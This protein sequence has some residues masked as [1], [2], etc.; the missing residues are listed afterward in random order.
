MSSNAGNQPHDHPGAHRFVPR[1][2]HGKVL[3]ANRERIIALALEHG[4]SNVRVFGSTARGTDTSDSDIDL[5]FDIAPDMSLFTL[6]RLEVA[7]ENLL[8]VNVDV[9]PARM[10]K[11]WIASRVLREATPL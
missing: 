9:V 6:G 3:A 7:L 5:L 10:L 11:P 8:G 4:A 2:E 1:S